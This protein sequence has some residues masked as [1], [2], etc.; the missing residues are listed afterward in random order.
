M[1]KLTGILVTVFLLVILAA[2]G[3]DDGNKGKESGDDKK[4]TLWYWN[5]GLDENVL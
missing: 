5:R 2:C 1:K 3:N 4:I